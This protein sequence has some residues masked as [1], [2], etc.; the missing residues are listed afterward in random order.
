MDLGD[1]GQPSQR[2]HEIVLQEIKE[3]P[4]RHMHVSLSELHSC[5]FISGAT[6]PA[7]INAHSQYIDMGSNGGRRCDVVRGPCACGAYH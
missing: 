2:T 6:D 1:D 7:L 3:H 4:E 5:C